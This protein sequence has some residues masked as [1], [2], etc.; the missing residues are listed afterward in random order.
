MAGPVSLVSSATTAD[1]APADRV[2]FWEDYNRKA[3]VGLACRSYSA[4]GLRATATNVRLRDV[5]IT[6]ISGNAHVVERTPE[7]ARTAPKD[8]VFCTLLIEGEA[9]FLHEHGCLPVSAGDLVVYETRQPYLFGFSSSM[10]QLLVDVPRQAFTEAC[11]PG[12]VPVPVRFGR[13]SASERALLS[14]LCT[15]LGD[16]VALRGGDRGPEDAEGEVL[17]LLRVLTVERSGGPAPAAAY[18]VV[19]KEH[20]ERRLHDPRLDAAEVAGVVGVSVR[21]LARV[22]ETVGTTPSRH[23]LERRL[24]RAKAE[25]GASGAADTRI[26]DIAY[27]WG[28]S[29]HAHFARAFH[30]RFGRTPSEARSNAAAAP[31]GGTAVG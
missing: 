19:A 5:L 16:L 4:R 12:G 15:L 6:D 17:E 24:Q 31:D 28:F 9:A 2:E 30:H 29:S 8:S 1:V 13:S 7:A 14:G 20:I 10:R 27:R 18:L 3:V 22:F 23:I 21:Q 25:L 11:L 26:A